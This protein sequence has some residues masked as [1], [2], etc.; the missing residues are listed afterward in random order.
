MPWINQEMC[1]NCGACIGVC[2]AG[3]IERG[4]AGRPEMRDDTCIRCGRCHDICPVEAVRHDSERLPH[5]V[6]QNVKKTEALPKH[7]DEPEDQRRLMERMIRHYGMQRKVVDDTI[8]RLNSLISTLA[9][10][11]S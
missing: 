1:V 7:D 6:E 9:D 3:A 11:T 2:P 10:A 5:L 4:A 8:V